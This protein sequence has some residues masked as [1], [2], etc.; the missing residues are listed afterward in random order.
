VQ[1][2]GPIHSGGTYVFITHNGDVT[3]TVPPTTAA[4]VTVA[5]H[6]GSIEADFPVQVRGD[7]TRRG[8]LSFRLG[9]GS[10]R[11]RIES[12]SGAIR[13]RRADRR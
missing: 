4:E 13:L 5:T 2:S 11:I 7:M 1:F 6:G 3:L 10:A 12:F 9:D 8:E